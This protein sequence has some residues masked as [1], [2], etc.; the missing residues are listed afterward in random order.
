MKPSRLPAL[1]ALLLALPLC[2][3]E[4]KSPLPEAKAQPP[5][6]FAIECQMVTIPG[7][8][9]LSLVPELNDEAKTAAAF[10]KLQ[11]MIA[12]GEATLTAHLS[13]Q[14]AWNQ[15]MTSESIEE[16]RY[17]TEYEP[18]QLP[19]TT[20]VEPSV[21]VLKNWPLVGIVPTAFETR[22][23]GQTLEF[24]AG[25]TADP[26]VV[27]CNYVAQHVRLE[28]FVKI[29]AGRLSNGD[30]LTVEQ[31]YFTSMKDQS[32]VTLE[33]GR[34]KLIG[35]HRLPG[36]ESVFELFILTVRVNAKAP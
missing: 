22:N 25:R 36:Q 26:K 15:K 34:P 21:E 5:G 12:S 31:P 7:K 4:P 8:L 18:P 32:Q 2:A 3:Q 27:V 35:V 17:A 28:K 20:P 30:R 29:D 13:S 10:A 11:G 19:S 16:V 9:V 1:A 23:V 33:H 6:A 14:G 24:E